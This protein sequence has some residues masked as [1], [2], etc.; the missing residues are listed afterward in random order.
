MSVDQDAMSIDVKFPGALSGSYA[1]SV[2]STT[3]GKLSSDLLTLDVHSTVTSVQPTSG[4]IY[5]GT[6]MTILG[7][8]F[9]DV[10]TDNPVKIGSEYC[11]VLT[12]STTEITCRTDFLIDQVAQ[13]ELLV[14]FL[15]T[16]EEA[17]CDQL[18]CT[19]TYNEPSLEV[20]TM[21]AYFNQETLTQ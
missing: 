2:T 4:S 15:K 17:I 5:G 10:I 21:T 12:T 19:F 16:S 20:T 6:L 8:N 18:I 11:Y 7:E 3:Y 9:S 14:V 1:L 13:D